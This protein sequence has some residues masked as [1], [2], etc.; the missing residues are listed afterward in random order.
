MRLSDLNDKNRTDGYIDIQ[1]ALELYVNEAG[2]VCGGCMKRS[3]LVFIM[4][5]LLAPEL[6]AEDLSVNLSFESPAAAPPGQTIL[7]VVKDFKGI[8]LHVFTDSRSSGETF[9]CELKVNGQPQKIRSQTA[10][11]DYATD[12]FRKTYS[13]LGGKITPD[14]PFAL[15]GEITHFAFD[16]ADGYQAKIGL[17]FQLLDDTG[18]VLWD[19]HSSGSVR[20]TGKMITPDN[21]AGIFS[22][23]LRATYLELLADNKLVGIWSGRVSNTYLIRDEAS[24]AV[25]AGN[26]K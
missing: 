13:E 16:E 21:L 25:P 14:G 1:T 20:G 4:L 15:K 11:A 7:P 17:H 12:V 23:I 3:L 8:K 2:I 26:G 24:I 22:D 19:G 10:L 5:L 9:L 18:R 6:S